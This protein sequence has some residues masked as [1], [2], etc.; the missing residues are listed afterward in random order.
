MTQSIDF[1]LQSGKSHL[2]GRLEALFLLWLMGALGCLIWS[3]PTLVCRDHRACQT[4][5]LPGVCLA[6]PL[7]LGYH[8]SMRA[9]FLSTGTAV[10][11]E[12]PG[13]LPQWNGGI[14]DAAA[15]AANGGSE[16]RD[17]P[18]PSFFT[19]CLTPHDL[20]V[21]FPLITTSGGPGSRIFAAAPRFRK[22]SQG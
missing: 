3:T 5:L 15:A 14:A 10:V 17:S 6:G 4:S 7:V 2:K 11:S 13:Q 16:L 1:H 9:L 20:H 19:H 8:I 12:Q 21:T 18:P 22:L